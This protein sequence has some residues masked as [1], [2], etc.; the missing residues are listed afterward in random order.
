MK[1]TSIGIF[2][3]REDAEKAI[4]SAHKELKIPADDISFVYKNTD[5]QL[6]EVDVGVFSGKT[7]GEGA[8]TGALVGFLAGAI[9]GLLTVIG[10]V[11]IVGDILEG[12]LG[13][14]ATLIGFTG[15][16]ASVTLSAIAG[17]VIGAFIGAVVN[18]PM[19]KA[20]AARYKD[21]VENGNIVVA[22]HA[23]DKIDVRSFLRRLGALD[24]RVYRLSL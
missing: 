22:I 20:P 8:R 19:G 18:V 1:Q 17:A 15:S 21:R 3:T 16:I 7:I 10:L 23:P 6:H 11:P 5:G 13:T 14:F 9:V 12:S 2:G 4:H 24:A